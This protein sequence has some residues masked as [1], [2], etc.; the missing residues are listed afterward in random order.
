VDATSLKHLHPD[1]IANGNSAL[2]RRNHIVW[3]NVPRLELAAGRKKGQNPLIE[4]TLAYAAF[5]GGTP[6][7]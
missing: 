5:F 1:V 6:R 4:L 3:D 7:F 2:V